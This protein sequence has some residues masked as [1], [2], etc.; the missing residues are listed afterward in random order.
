VARAPLLPNLQARGGRESE[1][2][3]DWPRHPRRRQADTVTRPP[4]IPDTELAAIR[5][6]ADRADRLLH[7]GRRLTDLDTIPLVRDVLAL[8]DDN[9]TLRIRWRE[10]RAAAERLPRGNHA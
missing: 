9:A 1:G 10:A 8:L 2:E 6:R 5:N 3:V 7:D 4:I